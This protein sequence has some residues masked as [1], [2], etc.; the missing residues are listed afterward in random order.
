VRAPAGYCSVRVLAAGRARAS[1]L[2][3]GGWHHAHA[4][5]TTLTRL[6]TPSATHTPRAHA[7]DA[8]G[9]DSAAGRRRRTQRCRMRAARG[10]EEQAPCRAV[11]ASAALAAACMRS[12]RARS[13]A[14]GG[15][16]LRQVMQRRNLPTW[17]ARKSFKT[18]A[19]LPP[20]ATV[21]VAVWR[22]R[23]SS[24]TRLRCCS[25]AARWA[26]R[27]LTVLACT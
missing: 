12:N 24:C 17:S 18:A 7:T 25:T 23:S 2:A 1:A 16:T 27:R 26:S 11:A 4:R 21:A 10:T 20:P 22:R 9:Q 8:A 14:A 15:M 19:L 5:L 13:G 3:A 6:S